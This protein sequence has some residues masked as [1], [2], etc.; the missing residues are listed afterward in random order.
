MIDACVHI[1]IR[2]IHMLPIDTH[3]GVDAGLCIPERSESIVNWLIMPATPVNVD[4]S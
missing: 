1:L 3:A 4:N 2:L